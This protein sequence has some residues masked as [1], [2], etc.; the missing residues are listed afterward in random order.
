MAN[1]N[2]ILIEALQAAQAFIQ[3]EYEIRSA[4][5]WSESEPYIAEPKALLD[6]IETAILYANL[7]P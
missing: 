3:E 4:S 2:P 5:G 1:S 6:K 7:Q